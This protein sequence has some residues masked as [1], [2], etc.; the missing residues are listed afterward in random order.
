MARFQYLCIQ[1]LQMADKKERLELT[2]LFMAQA[3]RDRRFYGTISRGFDADGVPVVRG[4]ITVNNGFVCASAA[5]QIELGK[6]LDE[7]V[8]IVLDEGL[9]SGV[10]A[11]SEI[12]DTTCFLN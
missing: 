2:E 4:K 10:G 8:K 9:H 6:R 11:T 3:D 12:A 5:T 7:L 1:I